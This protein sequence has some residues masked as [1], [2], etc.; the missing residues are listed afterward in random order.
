MDTRI[1]ILQENR[2]AREDMQPEHGLSVFLE[3]GSLKLLFD[4]GDVSGLFMENA[5][6]LGVDLSTV[7]CAAFSHN[8]YDHVGG[9]PPFWN[10]YHGQLGKDCPVYAGRDFFRVKFWDHSKDDPESETYGQFLHLVGPALDPAWLIQN[11]VK[12]FRIFTGDTLPLGEEVYLMGNLSYDRDFEEVDDSATMTTQK[13]SGVVKDEFYDEQAVVVVFPDSLVLLTGCAH[14][15]VVNIIRKARDRFGKPVKAVV[16]GTHLIAAKTD[17]IHKTIDWFR[18]EKIG[19]VGACH[20][21]GPEGLAA[22]ET[23]VPG[24]RFVGAGTVLEF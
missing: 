16:G 24:Y 13:G 15:G 1:T 10:W 4:M 5:K 6:A 11:Q 19:L 7:N 22:F 17:R 12:G 23:E 14:N 8:H 21:T 20:C 2:A 18:R 9:F 3:R